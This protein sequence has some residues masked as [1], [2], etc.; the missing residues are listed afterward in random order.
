MNPICE[1]D[2]RPGGI[3]HIVM[4]GPDGAEYPCKGVYREVVEPARLVYTDDLSDLP[5]E[6]HDLVDPKRDK[7]RKPVLDCVVTVTFEPERDAR[8]LLTIRTRFASPTI[9]DAMLKLKM[10]EGWSESL[11]RLDGFLAG[12]R[13]NERNG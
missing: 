9:R 11:E 4:R 8:T 5:E 12:L 2:V 7:T 1:L 10:S 6:W 13:A 3:R